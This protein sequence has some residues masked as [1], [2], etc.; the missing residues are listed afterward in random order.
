MAP[1]TAASGPGFGIGDLIWIFFLFSIIQPL[2]RQR[3][4]ESARLKMMERLEKK[5]KSRVVLLVHRQETMAFLGFP[6]LRYISVEDSEQLV[7]ALRMTDPAMPIDLI[8]HTPGGLQMA[9]LQI[10]NAILHRKG[11]VTVIVPHYA[12]SG[13]TLIALAADEILMDEHAV[14]GPIDPQLDQL[15][16]VSIL[17]AVRQKS[18]D[19]I[20]DKTLILADVAEK[21]LAQTQQQVEALLRKSLPP[22]RAKALS[23]ELTQGRWTHDYPI[24][25]DQAAAIGLPVKRGVPAEVYELMALFPQAKHGNVE[26]VPRIYRPGPAKPPARM[27]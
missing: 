18:K 11:K 5:R 16:A 6:L 20:D 9:S 27:P 14:L 22:E 23:I 19:E 7:R 21:A 8:L 26:F 24:T 4:I 25:C 12:M 3:W 13:G 10:A 17:A 1:I 15:P 2:L